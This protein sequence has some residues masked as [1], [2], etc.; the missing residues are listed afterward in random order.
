MAVA[1]VC[2]FRTSRTHVSRHTGLMSHDIRDTAS[3]SRHVEGTP[4]H[5]RSHHRE[6]TRRRGRLEL[7]RVPLVDYG[8][9][10]PLPSRGR[11]RVRPQVPGAEE[12]TGRTPHQTVELVLRLRKELRGRPRRR[13]GH[14][15]VAPGPTPQ[16]HLV[17]GH[18]P[19]DPD[20]PRRDYP[21]AEEA[22]EV[23]LHP[24]PGSRCRTR[25]WQ[26]DFT[27]YP[28][29]DTDTFPRGIEIITW[30]DDCTRYALH[31]S[32]H[33]AD[34]HPDRDGHLPQRRRSAR[35][36]RIDPDRQR[37]GLH[38]PPGRHRPPGWAQRIRAT[39]PRLARRPEELPTQPP[40]HLRQGRTLP[41]DHEEVAT[42]PTRP[43]RHHR[44]AA[45]P[46]ST[47]SAPSTTPPAPTGPCRTGP[48]PQRSTTPCPRPS[49]GRTRDTDTHDRIRHDRVDKSGTVTL[50][51][52]RPT[53]PHR[54]RTN[55]PPNPRHPA[56]PGPRRPR[57]Q[58]HHRRTP[59]RAHHRH[60]PRL[61]AHDTAEMTNTRT[62]VRGFGLS[63]MS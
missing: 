29:T 59:P 52:A 57:H 50:R 17:P 26:S 60:R 37:H 11:R 15:A 14:P 49:P 43:A 34:H 39:A 16:H 56:H 48:P 3:A 9:P 40:H 28:L 25:C 53:T 6:A 24:L 47:S 38:R 18:D 55:P 33:R 61:P 21:R 45:E 22:P 12:F 2:W 58:R 27:H 54:H 4:G 46:C 51:V 32:A 31:V 7:R 20:P 35:H 10:G 62:H 8:P 1:V 13:P 5:H 30:L 63:A 42:R 41:T 23:V 19:P 44:R 36:P